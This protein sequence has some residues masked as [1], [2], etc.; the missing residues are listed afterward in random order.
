M[1]QRRP[2]K[3]VREYIAAQPAE[4]RHILERVRRAIRRAV[5]GAAEGISYGIPA[6]T[7][8]GSTVLFF[9]GWK[10]HYS[11]Y[12]AKGP[13][14]LAFKDE[15]SRYEVDNGTIRFSLSKPV[16]VRLI[17]RI[18]KFRANEVGGEARRPP[19]RRQIR[20]GPVRRGGVPRA[21]SVMNENERFR[22]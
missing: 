8:R 12:P 7:L 20:R 14:A 3:S 2:A 17:E 13:L 10:E 6:Y 15:L 19:R 22:N 9:A 4:V 5:P 18:A 21:R 1:T 11:L 16:P